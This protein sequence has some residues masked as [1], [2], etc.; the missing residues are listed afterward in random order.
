MVQRQDKNDEPNQPSE[1]EKN[2]FPILPVTEVA[3]QWLP[4]NMIRRI[5]SSDPR[6]KTVEFRSGMNVVLA[7]Q[8]TKSTIKDST[9]GAGKSLLVD[10]I[11][12]LFGGK[13]VG[14][15]LQSSE[16]DEVVFE[17]QLL[18]GGKEYDVERTLNGGPVVIV[19]DFAGW[20]I[21]PS[22][23]TEKGHHELKQSHWTEILGHFMF[24][25]RI[26]AD[27]NVDPQPSF[28]ELFG[29]L[30]RRQRDQGFADP[31]TFHGKMP[32]GDKQTCNAYLL[33]LSVEY[34]RKFQIL[35]EK[36]KHLG[37]VKRALKSG[38]L[39]GVAA[40]IGTVEAEITALEEVIADG[41][42]ALNTFRVLEQYSV[43]EAEANKLT[44]KLHDEEQQVFSLQGMLEHYER[45]F[46]E[47]KDPGKYHVEALYRE[48]GVIFGE[49]VK[50][51]L[52]EVDSF[53]SR[54]VQNRR[55][56]L[57]QEI[58]RIGREIST[59][60]AAMQTS[61]VRRSE[62][63]S[64]LSEGGALQEFNKLQDEQSRRVGK[65][66]QLRSDLTKL[67]LLEEG[68]I[69]IDVERATLRQNARRDLEE[70]KSIKE[71]AQKTFEH[72]SR[73]LYGESGGRLVIDLKEDGSGYAF[74]TEMPRSGSEG[75]EMMKVFCY[76]LTVAN[77]LSTREPSPGLLVHDSSIFH[78][79]DHR[80]VASALRLA[81]RES[82]SQGY[83]YICMLNRDQVPDA[84]LQ[85]LNFESYVMLRLNDQETGGL[86]GFRLNNNEVNLY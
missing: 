6:F 27:E 60:Q 74:E 31:F 51:R 77:Q 41:S 29:F 49:Q 45:S 52:E 34:A 73:E 69:A 54:L 26:G 47:E 21:Q 14:S 32:E 64:I 62:L 17:M 23:N 67:K 76:D 40:K 44:R 43:I 48:A 13:R 24:G 8:T 71:R 10:I 79:T 57:Q 2:A 55:Q 53:H 58:M 82:I 38:L 28:R 83:Q 36:Q 18:L 75:I 56:F 9:N 84:E 22:V 59:I 70:R 20:P 65:L 37:A 25:L 11:H 33:G 1:A 4:K 5:S 50:K 16:L 39:P 3:A 80:Q 30:A 46:E 12:F 42:R 61:D 63:M 86:L 66:E 19:G 68:K 35:R 85:G 81:A 15:A 7:E 72:Y 78:P